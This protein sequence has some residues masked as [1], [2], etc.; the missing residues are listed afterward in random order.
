L[1]SHAFE[2]ANSIWLYIVPGSMRKLM[3]YVKDRYNT[4]IV[5]ITENGKYTMILLY[6][7]SIT[8]QQIKQKIA[9]FVR[10][11]LR[12]VSTQSNFAHA[13]KMRFPLFSR[14]G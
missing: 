11:Y 1:L 10:T 7:F 13:R 2:Q 8:L 12:G 9:L 3:N 14:Y 6:L 5:Y 4:P